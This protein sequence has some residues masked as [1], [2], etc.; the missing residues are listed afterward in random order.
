MLSAWGDFL[1]WTEKYRKAFVLSYD[2]G[3]WQDVRLV[4]MLNKYGLKCTF[5]L[6][7]G[8]MDPPYSW[9]AD[10]VKIE[11]MPSEML[12]GLYAGHEIACHTAHHCDLTGLG[13]GEIS[14]EVRNDISA[15]EKIAGQ[16]VTGFA[17]PY[18][19]TD[20]RVRFLLKMCGVSYARGVRSTHGF[21]MPEDLLEISPTCRHKEEKIFDLAR[22]FI[23]LQPESPKLFLLWGHS[24]EFDMQRGWERFERFCD[25]IAGHDD[26]FY[27]TTSQALL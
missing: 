13:D 19:N 11:R 9:E 17:Y 4:E 20:K 22:E 1:N 12:P 7:S 16:R 2:D 15:L 27:A 8:M 3:V 25:L 26:I 18:G 5:N 6:N 21:D 10:G 23:A 14:D 24:Y